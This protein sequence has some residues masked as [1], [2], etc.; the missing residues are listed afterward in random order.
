M[1]QINNRYNIFS[2]M[3]KSVQKSPALYNLRWPA[4]FDTACQAFTLYI[5]K[6]NKFGE[7]K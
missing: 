3:Y 7:K 1:I 5:N 6:T 4:M 2:G